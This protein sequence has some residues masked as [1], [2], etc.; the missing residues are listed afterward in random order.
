MTIRAGR[1]PTALASGRAGSSSTHGLYR[2]TPVSAS[3]CLSSTQFPTN[4]ACKS[5]DRA[6]LYPAKS[7]TGRSLGPT[8]IAA[9]GLTR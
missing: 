8:S 5:L 7:S 1:A 2:N 3:S 9:R 6:V 4:V